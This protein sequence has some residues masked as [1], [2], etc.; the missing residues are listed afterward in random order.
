M[1]ILLHNIT[2]SRIPLR[3]PA[4]LTQC[5][6]AEESACKGSESDGLF[7]AMAGGHIASFGFGKHYY[8]YKYKCVWS[9]FVCVCVCVCACMRNTVAV[10]YM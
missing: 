6:G 4:E 2:S 9:V 1:A 8:R 7:R 5:E 3:S 10:V